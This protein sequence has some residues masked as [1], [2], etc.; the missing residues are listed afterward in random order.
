MRPPSAAIFS[1]ITTSGAVLLNCT[2]KLCFSSAPTSAEGSATP[3]IIMRADSSSAV[4]AG[5]FCVFRCDWRASRSCRRSASVRPC[6]RCAC[7]SSSR[8]NSAVR[9]G[10][11]FGF[12]AFIF[13]RCGF[14]LPNI[15]GE[16]LG[17]TTCHLSLYNPL[18]I[19]PLNEIFTLRNICIFPWP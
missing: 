19:S 12:C 10:D 11:S 14:S 13:M 9:S 4:E 7:S 6:L 17:T 8:V 16:L 5:V 15:C 2:M 18:T 3:L 1:C